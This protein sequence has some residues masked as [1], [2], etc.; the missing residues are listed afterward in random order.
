MLRQIHGKFIVGASFSTAN[1]VN[2][3]NY[4]PGLPTDEFGKLT[5]DRLPPPNTV[6]WVPRRKA[7]V[8]AALRQGLLTRDGA[9]ERYNLSFDE[10]QAWEEI[11]DRHGLPGLRVTLAKHYRAAKPAI[12][13]LTD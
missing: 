11:V 6:R 7:V 4:P 9:C 13:L 12:T 2:V 8:I 3:K 5:L 1:V 10:L